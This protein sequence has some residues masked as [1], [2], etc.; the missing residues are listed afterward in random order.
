M[1]YIFQGF[2]ISGLKEQCPTNLTDLSH[3]SI[4]NRICKT[5]GETGTG[6]FSTKYQIKQLQ[7]TPYSMGG[8]EDPS[9]P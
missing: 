6:H 9:I 1:M 3:F 8:K 4:R 7:W 2:S 5:T